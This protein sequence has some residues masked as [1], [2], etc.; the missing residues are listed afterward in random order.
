[1]DMSN[2]NTSAFEASKKL[3]H[4]RN[5]T[6]RLFNPE[7]RFQSA[8]WKFWHTKCLR[9]ERFIR[10]EAQAC[11]HMNLRNFAANAAQMTSL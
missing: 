10:E 5:T 2:G 8:S 1:M 11:I 3:M 6:E 4:Y 9:Q 7:N